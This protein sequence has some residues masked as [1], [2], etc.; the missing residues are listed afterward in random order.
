MNFGNTQVCAAPP[1]GRA[2]ALLALCLLVC[3]RS[4]RAQ[5]LQDQIL[6]SMDS[7]PFLVVSVDGSTAVMGWIGDATQGVLAGAAYVFENNGSEWIETSKLLP[8]DGAA[9]D[10]FGWAVAV[11]EDLV[12][13]GA[14]SV[15]DLGI[16]SGAVYVFERSGTDWNE[17]AKLVASDGSAS[18]RFGYSVDAT[19]ETIVVG[20]PLNGSGKAYVFE[21]SGSQW[22]EV[23]KFSPAD[24]NAELGRDVAIDGDLI[25]VGARNHEVSLF[26]IPGAAFVFRKLL[27]NGQWSLVSTILGQG[28]RFAE[29]VDISGDIIVVGMPGDNVNGFDSGS[30]FVFETPTGDMWVQ[31]AKLLPNDGQATD[32]FGTSV[33]I[34]DTTILIGAPREDDVTQGSDVGAVYVFCGP[35]WT[36]S[37]KLLAPDGAMGDRFGKSLDLS[38]P[39]AMIVGGGAAYQV[40]GLKGS[41]RSYCT[42]S[43]NSTGMAA[44][45]GALGCTSI[46]AN[47]FVLRCGLCPPDQFGV[48]F[49]GPEVTRTPFGNGFVCV[50]T[51]KT[52]VFRLNPPLQI[53]AAGTVQRLLD[54]GQPPA[55]GGP[56]QIVPGATWNFQFWYRDPDAG[57]SNFNLSDGLSVSFVP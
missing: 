15:D 21:Q 51:G 52:G 50:G 31:S 49:Y 1:W 35:V 30:A 47:E 27:V 13:V 4:A 6:V 10:S 16:D 24:G 38:A 32:M 43:P 11:S 22:T 19:A 9:G 56:G 42:P 7:D 3:P 48:F 28:Q 44:R 37:Q 46:S 55:G 40:S 23:K 14:L 17:S 34:L 25:V 53:D 12:V 54:F 57:G 2:A 18:H 29:A 5:C 39:S 20:A 41:F 8:S 33:A 36:Q 45:I 26:N